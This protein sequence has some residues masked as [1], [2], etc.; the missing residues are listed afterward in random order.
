M[1]IIILLMI[2]IVGMFIR[3]NQLQNAILVALQPFQTTGTTAGLEIGVE[4]P[5]FELADTDGNQVS[6]E[7]FAGQK[8]LLGFMSLRCRACGPLYADLADLAETEQSVQFIVVSE[9]SLKENRRLVQ[10]QA[11]VFPVLVWDELVAAQY[12]LPGTPFFYLVDED[13]VIV[14][15]GVATTLGQVEELVAHWEE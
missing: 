2:A 6:L 1:G 4:A 13:G 9:G 3:M 15:R 10:Q 5:R 7:D 14:E 11:L 8:V 12:E